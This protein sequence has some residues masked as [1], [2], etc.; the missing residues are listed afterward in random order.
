MAHPANSESFYARALAVLKRADIPVIV[1]GAYALEAYTGIRRRTGDFDLFLRPGDCGPA[2]RALREE[3]YRGWVKSDHWLA[4]VSDGRD[5]VDLIFGAG[6]G[7]MTVDD[8]WFAHAPPGRI[9]GRRVAF[10]P[11]E[12][13]IWSKSF[14]MERERFDG[15]D[16]AHL[17]LG[18]RGRLDWGRLLERFAGDG[19]VLLAHLVIY[20]Y[21][22]PGQK[23]YV[24]A[25][26]MRRLWAAEGKRPGRKHKVCLGTRVSLQFWVDVTERGFRDGRVPPYGPLTPE[27]ARR[28]VET[29]K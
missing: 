2:L 11:A 29:P 9:F 10:V 1:G 3:G 20:R 24:P 5:Q 18:L 8:S 17:I 23:D 25:W 28:W 21:A 6:N 13:M 19:P 12:E 26:V 14:V 15:A 4:K 27:Q 16:I 22:F 7:V